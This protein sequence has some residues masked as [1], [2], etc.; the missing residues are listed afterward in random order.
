MCATIGRRA[1]SSHSE[2]SCRSDLP[3][4]SFEQI[5][6]AYKQSL[7]IPIE[8][9]ADVRIFAV[10]CHGILFS[11]FVHTLHVQCRAEAAPIVVATQ[12][13]DECVPP[14]TDELQAAT[15]KE[16]AEVTCQRIASNKSTLLISSR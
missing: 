6:I 11:A 2:R 4:D 14:L 10:L 1:A 3:E 12:V 7:T 9:Q 13:P 5:Y 8:I 15:V 16:V